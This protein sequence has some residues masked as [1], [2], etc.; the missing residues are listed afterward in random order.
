M[1]KAGTV[2]FK[3]V[4]CSFYSTILKQPHHPA[5]RTATLAIV[6]SEE[7]KHSSEFFS[8][9]MEGVLALLS[10]PCRR[11]AVMQD[12]ETQTSAQLC[13]KHTTLS[14]LCLQ[15]YLNNE[16]NNDLT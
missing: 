11:G 12:E 10:H 5:Y 9:K 6:R 2:S 1:L 14:I 15:L 7:T 4:K 3:T 16:D 13:H 8:P